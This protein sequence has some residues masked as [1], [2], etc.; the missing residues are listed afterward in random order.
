VSDLKYGKNTVQVEAV[1]SE[2][3]SWTVEEFG[4]AGKA[5]LAVPVAA[6]FDAW[7]S[8]H[9]VVRDVA[10]DAGRGA[11]YDAARGAAYDAARGAAYD[12]ARGAA[13]EAVL[14]AVVSDLISVE[15]QNVLNVGVDAVREFRGE[16]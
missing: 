7:S 10:Y 16:K 12:A 1:L 15:H 9:D 2:I 14:C 6:Y 5:W 4:I 3:S 11:A 8:V 13:Y